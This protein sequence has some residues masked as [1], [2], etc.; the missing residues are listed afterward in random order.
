MWR[1][2]NGSAELPLPAGGPA[3]LEVRIDPPLAYA[4]AA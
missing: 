2:T 1:W 4:V 3:V